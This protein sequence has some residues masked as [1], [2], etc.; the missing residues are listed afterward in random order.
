MFSTE[1]CRFSFF[2]VVFLNIHIIILDWFGEECCED[3]DKGLLLV[4]LLQTVL[5][6]KLFLERFQKSTIP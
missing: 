6:V 2:P 3:C 1:I 5:F 4:G